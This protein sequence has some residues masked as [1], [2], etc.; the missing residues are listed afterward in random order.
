MILSPPN[1]LYPSPPYPPR[2]PP[3]PPVKDT[4]FSVFSV[5]HTWG[6]AL[7]T[8]TQD[9]MYSITCH[10]TSA[11]V[12]TSE[13]SSSVHE[14]IPTSTSTSTPTATAICA[15][16]HS[17]LYMINNNH[18]QHLEYYSNN[19]SWTFQNVYST[20][21][22]DWIQIASPALEGLFLLHSYGSWLCDIFVLMKRGKKSF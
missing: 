19:L 8:R 13:V 9:Q 21:I 18:M 6:R 3:Y 14:I 11:K 5:I 2:P 7:H 12:V 4:G 20:Y 22:S 15:I 10:L 1:P 17:T 16:R